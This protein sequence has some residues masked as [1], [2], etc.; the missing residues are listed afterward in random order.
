MNAIYRAIDGNLADVPREVMG[1]LGAA[2]IPR[3]EMVPEHVYTAMGRL[4]AN[5][6]AHRLDLVGLHAKAG[7]GEGVK[8][9]VLDVRFRTAKIGE[10]TSHTTPWRANPILS[11]SA[12]GDSSR[13][14]TNQ[15]S[16]MIASLIGA[17]PTEGTPAFGVAPGCQLY[18]IE[19]MDQNGVGQDRHI[20]AG[21]RMAISEGVDIISL[22]LG[23]PGPMPETAAALRAAEDA[24]I[25]IFAA[26]GNEGP[27]RFQSFPSSYD[28]CCSVA[29]TNDRGLIA[30]FSSRHSTVD[31]A[32]PGES[33]TVCLSSGEWASASG[34]SFACP[35]AAGVA[36][37]LLGYARRLAVEKSPA[38]TVRNIM[39]LTCKDMLPP[40]KDEASGGGEVDTVAAT[41]KVL[42]DSAPNVPDSVVHIPLDT[43]VLRDKKILINVAAL[44]GSKWES[45]YVADVVKMRAEGVLSVTFKI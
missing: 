17:V 41:D 45:V 12:I 9:A 20:A 23:G 6:L 42:R 25:I 28:E 26:S 30:Q 8:L 7:M 43:P 37:V 38:H 27:G 40:G 13:P 22:S 35:A 39:E 5:W 10:W 4:P 34:T 19:V 36:A 14:G 31:L 33:V 32:A 15:H 11:R 24:G 1:N 21:I 16:P 18:V 44:V 2:F 29:A 3:D